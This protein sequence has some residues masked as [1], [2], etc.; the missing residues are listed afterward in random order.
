[1]TFPFFF[2]L[3]DTQK[4]TSSTSI[5][6]FTILTS[7][8]TI[9][10]IPKY[11]LLSTKYTLYTRLYRIIIEAL[12]LTMTTLHINELLLINIIL[13]PIADLLLFTSSRSLLIHHVHHKS[14]HS[15]YIFT[16][17]WWYVFLYKFRLNAS[18]YT[19]NKKCV[20]WIIY[21]IFWRILNVCSL[22]R[23]QLY[24]SNYMSRRRQISS[25]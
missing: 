11:I 25:L 24:A 9:T 6:L 19:K 1:M 4:L 15:R 3:I 23:S 20:L 5:I 14:A 21:V 13:S 7:D 22:F 2:W 17:K 18:I 10:T 8:L 16:V 12:F